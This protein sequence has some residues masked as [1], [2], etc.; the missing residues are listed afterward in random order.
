MDPVFWAPIDVSNLVD[1]YGF[2]LMARKG[3]G[4][5]EIAATWETPLSLDPWAAGLVKETP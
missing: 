2:D 1:V 3:V 4:A 5:M